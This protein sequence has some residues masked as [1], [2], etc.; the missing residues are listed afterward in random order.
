MGLDQSYTSSGLVVV[1]RFGQIVASE[2]CHS[3]KGET[4]FQRS[5]SLY[6]NILKLVQKHKIK[7][8]AIEG[9]AFGKFGN[10]TR[11]LAILQGVLV[12]NLLYLS[13]DTYCSGLEKVEIV[14]PSALK[15]YAT[16]NGRAD[17][18]QMIKHVP[19][20]IL[21]SW[22]AEFPE[23]SINDLAD[24]YFLAKKCHTMFMQTKTLIV[25]RPKSA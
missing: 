17:K 13:G 9:L 21:N 15:K 11:S 20:G 1:D 19:V 12:T 6:L 4:D 2:I 25:L 16:G 14:T 3:K 5:W 23:K 7:Y 8:L 24:A 10:A 22:R 18:K